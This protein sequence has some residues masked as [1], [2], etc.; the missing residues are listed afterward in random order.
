MSTLC[1]HFGTCGG[2]TYQDLPDAEYCALKRDLVIRALNKNGLSD[3]TVTDIIEVAPGTRRRCVFKIAKRTGEVQIGFHARGSHSIVDMR[4][5]RVLTPGLFG[6]AA[7]LRTVMGEILNDGENAE[8]HVTEADNGFDIALRWPRK[9]STALVA[10][11]AQWAGRNNIARVTSGKDIL[12][13]L[14]AP[15]LR[16]A[17]ADIRLPMDAFLQPSR[18]GEIALQTKVVEA[19]SGAKSIADLFAGCG[20]F[21]F[22]LAAK[23]KVHAVEFE[24]AMLNALNAAA[25]MAKGL[26]PIT[27]EKRDLFKVPLTAK[28]LNQFDAVVLD[29]PRAGAAAQVAQ[30]AQSKVRRIAYVS[31]SAETFARDAR[32]L[33][34]AG[35]QMGNV[36]P[37]DQ[38]LWSEHIELVSSFTRR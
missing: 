13:E 21:T 8:A 20:T 23:A 22:A 1:Q 5:C 25:K 33:V 28:E 18:D 17:S 27:T 16:V 10:Q 12:V 30:L 19:L 6:L 2:C 32:V 35:F 36:T 7:K 24:A 26:K 34:D 38:F 15:T 14:A 37:V 9:T 3:A 4:E 29:P 11:F 31:C